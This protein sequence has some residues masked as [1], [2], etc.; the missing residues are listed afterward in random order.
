[1]ATKIEEQSVSLNGQQANVNP[2]PPAPCRV[3]IT[4]CSFEQGWYKNLIGEEFDVDKAGGIK[5]Y[6]LWEDY[7]RQQTSWR[8]IAKQDCVV[9]S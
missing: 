6:V 2:L 1:M 5:D 8:H 4:K 9:I 3:R 7:A